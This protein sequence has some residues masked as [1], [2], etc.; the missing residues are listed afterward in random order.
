MARI[1][2]PF[3]GGTTFLCLVFVALSLRNGFSVPRVLG[4][5]AVLTLVF[6]LLPHVHTFL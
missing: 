3:G 5:T 6:G 4:L 1:G 2:K